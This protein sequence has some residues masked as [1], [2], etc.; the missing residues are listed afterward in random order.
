MA[1]E[2]NK[3]TTSKTIYYKLRDEIINL[4]LE[5]GT[6]ISERNFRKSIV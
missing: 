2:V 4:Y 5:P 3:N 1:L 6:S